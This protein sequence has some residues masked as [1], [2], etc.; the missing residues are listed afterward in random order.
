MKRKSIMKKKKY[1]NLEDYDLSDY[2]ELTGDI[3]YKINGGAQIE[4][5][6]EA[7]AGAKPGDTLIREDGTKMTIKQGDIDWAKEKVEASS[8]NGGS[9]SSSVII[10]ASSGSSSTQQN[11]SAN[12]GSSS[13]VSSGLSN[14]SG[15]NSSSSANSTN[16]TYTLALS[17]QQQYGMAKAD[18]EKNASYKYQTSSNS[19]SSNNL[20]A[21]NNPESNGNFEVDYKNKTIIADIHNKESIYDAYN[22]YDFWGGKG[23]NL[24]LK[25]GADIV[26]TF[27]DTSCAFEYVRNISGYYNE[28][29]SLKTLSTNAKAN[30]T[31]IER[32]Q[33]KTERGLYLETTKSY[34]G[35]SVETGLSK[36]KSKTIKNGPAAELD[37]DVL[38]A[39]FDWQISKDY[40]HIGFGLN[41]INASGNLGGSTNKGSLTFGS[42]IGIGTGIDIEYRITSGKLDYLSVDLGFIANVRVNYERKQ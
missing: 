27:K 28:S 4:N 26:H 13:S 38:T 8:G 6:N 12:A 29:Y 35:I 2:I 23:Y 42:S 39:S 41:G 14:S 9:S 15:G 24:Q 11:P 19:E 22:V 37:I 32:G 36:V 3:L 16:Q 34:R 20:F 33:E 5:S 7:V 30:S 17:P 1:P 31:Y 18:A 10:S 40:T 21:T 25:D